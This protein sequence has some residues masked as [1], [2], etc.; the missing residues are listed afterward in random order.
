MGN[1]ASNVSAGKPKVG[2]AIYY[3]P[4]TATLPTTATATLGSDF[5][6]VG[7]IGEDGLKNEITRES[8][9]IKA[10]GG[11]TVLN[12]QTSFGE[13]FG[14]KLIEALN[15][16][17]LKAVHGDD[18]VTGTALSSGISVAVGSDEL[19]E[20]AWVVDMNMSGGALKRIV[21]PVAKI[22]EVGEIVYSDSEAIGY[23]VTLTAHP[24]SASKYS[25][26]YLQTPTT[27]SSTS[28][29]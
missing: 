23:D 13:T 17:V 14:F 26:E 22:T 8:E 7:Y 28:S 1:T 15:V 4:T 12:P 3:G 27:T 10:W 5:K 18:A 19:P 16:D 20:K 29:K 2:G 24:D 6:C 11:D 9:D 21:I 25:Y